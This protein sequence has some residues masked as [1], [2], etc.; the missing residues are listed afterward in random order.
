MRNVQLLLRTRLGR[1]DPAEPKCFLSR[2]T[3]AFLT[4]EIRSELGAFGCRFIPSFDDGLGFVR[5][6]V[7]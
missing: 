5:S 3:R 7:P 6:Q 2:D 1:R 4:P